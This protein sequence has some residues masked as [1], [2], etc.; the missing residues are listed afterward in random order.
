V[1]DYVDEAVPVLRA[2][3]AR[4]LKSYFTLGMRP[5]EGREPT[6]FDH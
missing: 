5:E 4:R 1:F 6:L 2:M 3:A